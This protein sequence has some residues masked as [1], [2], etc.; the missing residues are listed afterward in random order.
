MIMR[1]VI[2]CGG[3]GGHIIPAIAIADTVK[4]NIKSAELLFVGGEQGMER[5]LVEGA[6]YPIVTLRVRGLSRSLTPQNLKVLAETVS[7][8]KAAKGILRDFAPDAVIGTGGYACYPTLRAATALGIPTALHESNAVPGLAVRLLAKRVDRIWLNFAAA[9][10]GLPRRA[11]VLTVGNPLRSDRHPAKT[12]SPKGKLRVLSFGGSLGAA[13]LN[14][15]IPQLMVAEQRQGG[16]AHLHA[17]GKGHCEGVLQALHTVGL[18][19][20]A[21]FCAVPFIDDMPARM[22]EADL[23]ICRAGAM[24]ISELAALGKAA[25]LIPS[26]NVTGNHQHKNAALLASAGAACLLTEQELRAGKLTEVVT[27][28]LRDADRRRA[29]SEAIS[30]FAVPDANRRILDDLRLLLRK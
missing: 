18:S 12:A 28:L 25:V 9:A 7:A 10:E 11:P 30:A 14:A 15:A 2:S 24:S 1:I 19:G 21:D 3:T 6:G 17:T 16:I 22:A 29:L 27:A 23:V 13:A 20:D 8:V 4:R 26:P 5:T